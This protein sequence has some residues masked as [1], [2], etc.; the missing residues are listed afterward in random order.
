V[1][2][3]TNGAAAVWV[4]D[5]KAQRVRRARVRIGPYGAETV[6]VL[7]GLKAGEWIVVAGGHL[8]QE[9]QPV[10]PVDRENRPIKPN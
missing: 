4:V 6:P 10:T 8:L 5:P 7:S 1:Q 3:A 9:G 2:A